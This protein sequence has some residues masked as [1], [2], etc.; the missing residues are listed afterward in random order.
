[1]RVYLQPSVQEEGPAE[2]DPLLRRPRWPTYH[3]IRPEALSACA[4]TCSHRCKK[5][6]RPKPTPFSVFRGGP[7]IIPLD[8]RRFRHARL[9]AAIGARRRTCPNPPPSPSSE[10]AHVSS[11]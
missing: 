9:P 3:P 1:M 6:D 5:K 10:V 4:F 2:T 7:R 11:H 8:Q